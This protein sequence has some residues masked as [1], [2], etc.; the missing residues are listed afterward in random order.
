MDDLYDRQ[1]GIV[2]KTTPD[3]IRTL[4]S[5]E[6]RDILN[7]LI[8]VRDDMDDLERIVKGELDKRGVEGR[9]V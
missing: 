7:N 3:K 4:R 6:L 5:S 8:L 9:R 2:W 1:Y